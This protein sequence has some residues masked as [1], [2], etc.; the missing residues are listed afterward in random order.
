M[1][2]Y[3]DYGIITGKWQVIQ[4]GSVNQD[5]FNQVIRPKLTIAF[6]STSLVI[7]II[8]LSLM[9]VSKKT[10]LLQTINAQVNVFSFFLSHV[11]FGCFTQ[12]KLV[13]SFH[14]FQLILSGQ[15]QDP[16]YFSFIKNHSSSV[17]QK[18]LF[19]DLICII[20]WHKTIC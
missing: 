7:P 18:I 12:Q 10:F 14:P 11:V 2:Q 20:Q 3:V 5:A 13:I 1:H 15:F 17:F 6:Y 9:G 4:N 16:Y 19:E 8:L